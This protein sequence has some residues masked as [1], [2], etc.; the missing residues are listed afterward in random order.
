MSRFIIPLVCLAVGSLAAGPVLAAVHHAG[1]KPRISL[2]E[3]RQIAKKAYPGQI[4]KE[5][6][7]HE[8]GGSGLRYSFDMRAGK[9]W[10]E[11][12]VDAVTGK[13]PGEQG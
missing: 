4:V 5:E 1:S 6:L 7:E 10:R 9:T 13:V 2:S 3:A 11:V 12:G 8:G